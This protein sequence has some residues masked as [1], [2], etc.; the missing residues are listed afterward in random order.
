VK[1]GPFL[2]LSAEFPDDPAVVR[3]GEKAGWLYLVMACDIRIH[4]GDGTIAEHRLPRLGVS[5]WQP[6]L[7][8]LLREGLVVEHP[9]GYHLPGYLKW[10][11][12]EHA[13]QKRSAEGKVGACNRHH[14]GCTRDDCADARHW[15]KV[16]GYTDG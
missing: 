2:A 6:R 13:Y 3:A 10:N 12:S 4:R 5:G 16:N 9:D 8:T 1:R 11:K 15:L 14:N 7:A